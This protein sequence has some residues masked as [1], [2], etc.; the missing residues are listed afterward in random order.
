MQIQLHELK[1]GLVISLVS[2][3]VRAQCEA[4]HAEF[5]QAHGLPAWV[6]T[7]V[8]SQQPKLS[9]GSKAPDN[10]DGSTEIT[11]TLDLPSDLRAFLER[12]F[13]DYETRQGKK[14]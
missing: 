3:S 1:T 11:L 7:I 8:G 2:V 13:S 6:L 9:A 5:L 10:V 12:Q 4:A 14:P